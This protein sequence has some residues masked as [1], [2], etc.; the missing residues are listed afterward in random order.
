MLKA[1]QNGRHQLFQMVLLGSKW[2]SQ[3]SRF[4]SSQILA[5]QLRGPPS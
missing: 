5:A 1:L 3:I 4:K 2:I